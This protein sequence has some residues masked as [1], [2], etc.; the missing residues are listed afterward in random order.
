MSKDRHNEIRPT[1]QVFTVEDG[2]FF[3]VALAAGV[4][5][6]TWAVLRELETGTDTV[7]VGW[8]PRSGARTPAAEHSISL[9]S[10]VEHNDPVA[11]A[12]GDVATTLAEGDYRLVLY[13]GKPATGQTGFDYIERAEELDEDAFSVGRHPIVEGQ[14]G[15]EGDVGNPFG[16]RCTGGLR[17][18]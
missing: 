7:A 4:P 9:T 16:S 15:A 6:F 2:I 11:G 8:K 1:S 12:H 3:E 10:A 17:R 13:S 18:G 5:A 14:T